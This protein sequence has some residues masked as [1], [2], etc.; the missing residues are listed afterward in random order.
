MTNNR[1]LR[2]TH[3][4][5]RHLQNPSETLNNLY[6]TSPIDRTRR[7]SLYLSPRPR[8]EVTTQKLRKMHQD[9]LLLQERE[10]Y[11]QIPVRLMNQIVIFQQHIQYVGNRVGGYVSS[12][13]ASAS[14]LLSKNNKS[15]GTMASSD[16]KVLSL[17]SENIKNQTSILT[18]EPRVIGIATN[19]NNIHQGIGT[20][21]LSDQISTASDV[22]PSSPSSPSSHTPLT[23]KIKGR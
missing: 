18:I 15:P 11:H 12:A 1:F 6:S 13:S 20:I 10:F 17:S 7:K 14:A 19:K 9:F 4:H 8:V 5:I 3:H 21:R 22:L 2:Q 23:T 16:S